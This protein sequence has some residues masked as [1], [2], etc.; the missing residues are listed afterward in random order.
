MLFP[1]YVC[2]ESEAGFWYHCYVIKYM[3]LRCLWCLKAYNRVKGKQVRCLC[4]PVTVGE[5]YMILRI[6]YSPESG[7]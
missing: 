6:R 1:G 4:D 7:H 3:D 5:E 2:V